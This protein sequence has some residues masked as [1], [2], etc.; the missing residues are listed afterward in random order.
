[1]FICTQ[2]I[3]KTLSE[4]LAKHLLVVF[5]YHVRCDLGWTLAVQF[6]HKLAVVVVVVIVCIHAAI[7]ELVVAEQDH[8]MA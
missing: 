4:N 7:F 8:K 5:L 2:L 6:V 3:C 1:M